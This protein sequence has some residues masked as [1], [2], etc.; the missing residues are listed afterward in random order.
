[1]GMPDFIVKLWRRKLF[2]F[3]GLYLGAA[4]IILQ[5]SVI[6]E[7]TLELPKW[8]DQVTLTFLVLGFPLVLIFAWAQESNIARADEPATEPATEPVT[9]PASGEVKVPT[10]VVE[11]ASTEKLSIAVLPFANMSEDREHEFFADGM[12]EDLLT[13]LSVNQHMSVAARTSSF[14]FKGKS[15]DVRAIGREL[16]VDYVVEGSVRAMGQRLRITAQLIQTKTGEHI[17]AEKYDRALTDLFDIQD[18]VLSNIAASLNTNLAFGEVGGQTSDKPRSLKNWQRVQQLAAMIYTGSLTEHSEA[19]P[20]LEKVV[21]EEPGYAYAASMLAFAHL[22]RFVNGTTTTLKADFERAVSLIEKGLK[23]AP[24][25]PMNLY[26]CASAAGYSGQY[27]RAID[28][29]E[30]GLA[31]N[32]NL[33]ELYAPIAQAYTNM[34]EYAKADEALDKG[35]AIKHSM[36]ADGTIWYRAI[37]RSTELRYEEAVPLLKKT[38]D[39]FPDYVLP[40]LYLANALDALGDRDGAVETI[41]AAYELAPQLNLNGIKV[42]LRS[43]KYPNEGEAERRIALLQELWPAGQDA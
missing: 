38:V 22:N 21:E 19:V 1:M 16:G 7:Q 37:L 39:S 31:V 10:P 41:N 40:R 3:G 28:L 23:L 26:F 43:Y 42:S 20:Q 29:A 11:E 5:L 6:I 36:W 9:E 4:W 18:E 8:I 25:D 15:D 32:P 35:D 34:G 2:Q 30:K 12:T 13:A 24:S 33:I 27:Q 17:W 14:K